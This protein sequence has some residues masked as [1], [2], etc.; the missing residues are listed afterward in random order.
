MRVPKK[1]EDNILDYYRD[2]ENV[3]IKSMVLPKEEYDPVKSDLEIKVYIS[4]FVKDP[5]IQD[6]TIRRFEEIFERVLDAD[7]TVRPLWSM[8][9]TKEESVNKDLLDYV[10][11][12]LNGLSILEPVGQINNAMFILPDDENLEQ[13]YKMTRDQLTKDPSVY[14]ISHTANKEYNSY[15]FEGVGIL[16]VINAV[17]NNKDRFISAATPQNLY[18]NLTRVMEQ[19]QKSL[20][21][22]ER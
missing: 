14:K 17:K 7:G 20:D 5:K 6:K 16:D 1:Y 18:S 4:K 19:Y 8:G 3:K 22:E 10:E 11:I 21:A 12:K 13:K 15:N 9:G 2:L